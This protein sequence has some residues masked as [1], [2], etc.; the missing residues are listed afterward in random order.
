M[1]RVATPRGLRPVA[2]TQRKEEEVED[3]AAEEAGLEE[4]QP[5]RRSSS[6]ALGR[7]AALGPASGSER[8]P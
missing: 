5:G 7:L 8:A 4:Q 6:H 2:G 3:D 1:G